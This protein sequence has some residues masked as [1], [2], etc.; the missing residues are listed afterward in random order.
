M[1]IEEAVPR[2]VELLER[3]GWATLRT[4][5]RRLSLDPAQLDALTHEL[6][7]AYPVAL[8]ADGRTLVWQGPLR[9]RAT[10]AWERDPEADAGPPR[11][12]TEPPAAATPVVPREPA[13]SDGPLI[14][15]ASE[16]AVLEA[17]WAQVQAGQSQAVLVTGDAGLGKSRLVQQLKQHVA[18]TPHQRWECRCLP[19]EQQS[20]FAPVIEL[21]HRGFH[22]MAD[23]PPPERLHKITAALAP[24]ALAQTEVVPLLAALLSLPLDAGYT[25]PALAP[26]QLRQRTLAA[27]VTLLRAVSGQAPVVLIV[28]DVHWADPSTLELLGLVWEQLAT[29]RVC[30]VLTCRPEFQAPGP[31]EGVLRRVPLF[32][33]R[34]EQVVALVQQVAGGT[35]LP[36]VVVQQ[37][38]QRTEGVPLYV[39][40]VT[41]MVLAGGHGRDP[42]DTDARP[43]SLSE[44][45]VPPTLHESLRAR[46]G[47]LGAAQVVAQV[48]SVWGRA[49]TEAQL[50]A[51]SPVDWRRLP[52]LVARLVEA[53]IFREIALPPRVTYVFKHAL[54]QEA[55]Y[56]MMPQELRQATHGTIGRLLETRFAETVETQP[57]LVAHH[58]TAAGLTDQAIGYWLRAGQ[59]AAQRSAHAEAI[60]HLTQGVALLTTLPETPERLHQELDLQVALGPVLFATKGFAAP[61]VERA[62]ARARE[63]CA[64]V[65]GTPELFPVMRG[66]MLYYLNR[67]Q[68][69][70]AT[71]L[72]EQLLRL[73]Q[74]QPDPALLMLA[75]YMLGMVLF[76]RGELVAAHT[77]HTQALALSTPQAHRALAVRYGIDLG[78]GSGSFLARELWRLGYP[79]QALQHSQESRTLAEEVSHPLSLAQALVF[80]AVVHQCRREAP[81]AHE[82]AAAVIQL[83]TE[84]GF[85][86]WVARGTVLHGW[87]LAMQGQGEAGLAAIR[88]GLAA[89]LATGATLWQPYYLA[90]LAEAY[91]AGRR[92]AEGVV[93]LA[94]ALVLVEQT[95]ARWN[96]AE[97]YRIKGTLLLHQAVPDAAQ[98]AACFQQALAIAR[99]QQAKSLELRAAMSLARLW[100]SQSKRQEA[101][102]LLAPVYEWFTEGFDTADLQEA[103]TL[104]DGLM[105]SS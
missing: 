68:L 67:G 30:V 105:T 34:P 12:E 49:V 83:A 51:T 81:A 63:L 27:M 77:H 59:R 61:D 19:T 91:G 50:Q 97:I 48:A 18:A 101:H 32:P 80:A 35:A 9:P 3:Q 78:V 69:Q 85:A 89:D 64:Q 45:G 94:E 21:F 37:I 74:A 16:V 23:D 38:V 92:A 25:L 57:E 26:A 53:E 40:E 11:A 46:L 90:L 39:E 58:Y 66:L 98:A 103:K 86:L 20:A 70:T 43:A 99:Q 8:N 56:G 15:R 52:R 102:D 5:R 93:V 33:L 24:F 41:R 28:E 95:G 13:W 10:S 96:E 7:T 65:G 100:Q 55:A 72:G 79:D 42:G 29:L 44:L 31:W 17:G 60:A 84:Q 1:T 104:L 76:Y 6:C 22:I 2:A 14:G 73:A 82:Q 88:Q 62:Y 36:A 54:I 47:S 87:A 71:A 4:L 75:H